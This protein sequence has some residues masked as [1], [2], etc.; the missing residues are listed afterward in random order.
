MQ[1]FKFIF[2]FSVVLILTACADDN[3]VDGV[4]ENEEGDGSENQ[5]ITLSLPSDAVS[6]DPHGSNDLPSDKVRQHIFEGLVT[7]DENLEIVPELAEN[8]E[9]VDDLTWHFFLR[10]DVNFHD[11]NEFNAEAVKANLDRLLDPSRASTREFLLEM[12]EEVNVVDEYTVEIITEYPFQPLLGH[13]THGAGDMMSQELIDEDYQNAL[14][15]A[16]ADISLEDYYQIRESGGEEHEEIAEE[17]SEYT[18]AVVEENPLG[19]GYME[20]EERSPG[21]STSLVRNNEYWNGEVNI[22]DLTLKVVPETGARVAEIETGESEVI[23]DIPPSDRERFESNEDVTVTETDSVALEYIGL[24]TESEY[25]QDKR[26]RQALAHA[27][28]KQEVI[29]GVYDNSGIEAVSPLAPEVF[30]FDD[31]LESPEYDLDEAR[32]LLEE[33]GY[34]DGFELTMYVNDDNPQ[35][36]DTAL[37][38][39]E[40]LQDIGIEL[41]VVQLEWATFLEATGEG[42]HDLYIM[43]WGNSTGDPD[44]AITPLFHTDRLGAPGNRAFFENEDVDRLLEEGREEADEERRA[45]IYSEI[46]EILIDES[47]AIFIMHPQNYN[48]YLS[49]LEG[50]T[51]DSYETFNFK[52]ITSVE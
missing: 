17:I 2:L 42:E 12:I 16:G 37:W 9:Q 29:E 13:L 33:A 40:S 5:S 6:V 15:E 44:N 39:Q 26:V 41:E 48:G 1:Y 31:S 25:L 52:D 38:F 23:A 18:G 10:E 35:R 11:G 47:P 34:E 51:I 30:G 49:N 3:N 27:F 4:S 45:E 22:A 21:E 46:Q 43:S 28:D 50:I 36:I 20:F 8:W 14:E 32:R 19:T 7:Q 24:N